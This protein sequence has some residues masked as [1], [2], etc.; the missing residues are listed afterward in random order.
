MSPKNPVYLR[1]LQIGDRFRTSKHEDRA[2]VDSVLRSN[3]Q[4]QRCHC[5]FEVAGP[6]IANTSARSLE[7]REVKAMRRCKTKTHRH[8]DQSRIAK[9][10][11]QKGHELPKGT[12]MAYVWVLKVD[13]LAEALTEL[14]A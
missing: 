7:Y 3:C 2:W 13:P 14:A 11:N 5:V 4:Y 10:R 6:I 9:Y 8:E 12:I 1:D